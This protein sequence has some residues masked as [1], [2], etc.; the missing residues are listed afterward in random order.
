M[1]INAFSLQHW[2]SRDPESSAFQKKNFKCVVCETN[3]PWISTLQYILI[4]MKYENQILVELY[5]MRTVS[6]K[7]MRAM[8]MLSRFWFKKG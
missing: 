4:K 6:L 7:A 1:F 2:E 5:Y 8:H 3:K